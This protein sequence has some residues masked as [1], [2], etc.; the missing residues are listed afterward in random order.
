MGDFVGP[1]KS[2]V[3]WTDVTFNGIVNKDSVMISPGEKLLY[4]REMTGGLSFTLSAQEKDS[5]AKVIWDDSEFFVLIPVGENVKL[6]MDPTS[7]GLPSKSSEILLLCVIA[8]EWICLFLTLIIFFSLAF[9][10]IEQKGFRYRIFLRETQR[11]FLD[12]II[13]GGVLLLIAVGL[14]FFRPNTITFNLYILLPGFIYFILKIIYRAFPSLPIILF[15]LFFIGNVITHWFWFDKGVLQISKIPDQTYNSLVRIVYPSDTTVLSLGY[16][17]QLRGSDLIVASGSFFAG[18]SKVKRLIRLNYH[19]KIYVLDY[20][21]ELTTEDY[22]RLLGLDGWSTWNR[23]NAGNFYFYK[24]E[25]PVASPIA[26]FTY[27]DDAFLIQVD[28]LD[29]LELFNDFIFD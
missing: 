18:E 16:Y 21:G 29:E 26:I 22:D 25:L 13:L 10:T 14:R 5:E 20:P 9:L 4:S 2:R 17:R 6:K 3:P 28:Q 27:E 23:R 7:L 8:N 24:V 19:E 15:G 1:T 11:Y 12:Y